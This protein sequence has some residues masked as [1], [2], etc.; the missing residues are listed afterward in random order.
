MLFDAYCIPDLQCRTEVAA[1]VVKPGIEAASF[2][3]ATVFAFQAVDEGCNLK[4]GAANVSLH[5]ESSPG[6]HLTALLQLQPV[7]MITFWI[8]L[9][10]RLT[11]LSRLFS[12]F[13]LF[14]MSEWAV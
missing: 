11:A 2:L 8:R 13:L 1:V 4:V 9:P 7:H 12:Y 5:V 10:L 14:F 6:E 3:H